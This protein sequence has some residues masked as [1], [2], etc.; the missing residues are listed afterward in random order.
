MPR[1]V[2]VV[3]SERQ[4]DYLLRL[5]RS[6]GCPRDVADRARIVLFAYEKCTNGTIAERLGCGRRAVR[7]CRN[8]WA[9]GFDRLVH[10]EC[11]ESDAAF[12]VALV[13]ALMENPAAD[14]ATV[15]RLADDLAAS[16]TLE[17][18]AALA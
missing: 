15:E 12:R 14:R 7:D 18:A 2:R 6:R 11:L 17:P 3:I 8:R 5:A 10:I 13:E 4:Q 9:G 1:K 16:E